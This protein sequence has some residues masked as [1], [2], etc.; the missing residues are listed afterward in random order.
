MSQGF[1]SQN[2]LAIPVPIASGGT[3]ATTAATAR[4][5][6]GITD[7]VLQMVQTVDTTNRST[8]SAT[9]V[10]SSVSVTITPASASSRILLLFNAMSG[11]SNAGAVAARFAFYRDTTSLIP[12]GNTEFSVAYSTA[13]AN[14]I[15]VSISYID[16]P[17]TTSAITYNI[18]WLTGTS[19]AYLGRRGLD[20]AYD[21]PNV[22]TAIEL[23]S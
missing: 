12:S 22:L 21:C 19:T 7:L 6:L 9:F 18:Y 2:N 13:N 15:P 16:S 14:I 1:A 11:N 5:N 8:T 10:N 20:T 4:S 23:R 3:E 17:A